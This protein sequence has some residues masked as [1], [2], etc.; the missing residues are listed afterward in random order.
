MHEKYKSI[1]MDDFIFLLFYIIL[2]MLYKSNNFSVY[3]DCDDL[4]DEGKLI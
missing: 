3:F 2:K 1:E 4:D